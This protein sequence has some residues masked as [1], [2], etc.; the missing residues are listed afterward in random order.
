MSRAFDYRQACRK[1][2]A[3]KAQ[4]SLQNKNG[5][6]IARIE[7]DGGLY[8]KSNHCLEPEKVL[9]LRDWLTEMFGE[10]RVLESTLEF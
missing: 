5:V 9:Q 1:A 3:L 8:L 2:A 7:E 10:H 4:L 6:V